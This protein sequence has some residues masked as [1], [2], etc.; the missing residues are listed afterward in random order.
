MPQAL[1]RENFKT[2]SE[3]LVAQYFIQRTNENYILA[4]GS[5]FPQDFY[6]IITLEVVSDPIM[7][8]L[9]LW[10]LYRVDYGCRVSLCLVKFL[11]Q[12]YQM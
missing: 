12:S 1:L 8:I 3:T 9:S 5:Q 6:R 7:C 2:S 10:P 11:P 4:C